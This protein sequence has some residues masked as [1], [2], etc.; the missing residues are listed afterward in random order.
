M[1]TLYT[2]TATTSDILLKSVPFI[3]VFVAKLGAQDI[4][5]YTALLLTRLKHPVD[6]LAVTNLPILQHLPQR[7]VVLNKSGLS[8]N[9]PSFLILPDHLENERLQFTTHLWIGSLMNS[10]RNSG[11]KK[12]MKLKTTTVANPCL[13][14]NIFS[15]GFQSV[16][17]G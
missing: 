10:W 3:N 4:K 5:L 16:M 2:Y 1:Q 8:P 7:P 13:S 15:L 12:L 14:L 17:G 9:H 11:V 6:P